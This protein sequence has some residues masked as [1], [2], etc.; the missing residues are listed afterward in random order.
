MARPRGGGGQEE[1]LEKRTSALTA[2]VREKSG[3]KRRETMEEQRWDA[4]RC[5]QGKVYVDSKEDALRVAQEWSDQW[6][7]M[8][9]DGS[10]L[11]GGEVGAAVAWRDN[12]SWRGSGTYLGTNKEVFDA[13][14]FVTL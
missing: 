12:S 11:E 2:R 3:L 14:V 5:F 6:G 8:W 13:E 7:A 1:I 4:L 9:T 10:R